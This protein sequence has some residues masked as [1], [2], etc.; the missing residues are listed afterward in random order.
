MSR[1]K[2]I[3]KRIVTLDGQVIAEASSVTIVSDGQSEAAVT[4][5]QVEVD[6]SP[7][8]V[9]SHASSHVVVME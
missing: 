6:I 9:H 2:V 7:N 4:Y 8:H 1:R 3:K 5:Q